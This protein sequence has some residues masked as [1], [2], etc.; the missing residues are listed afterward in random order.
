MRRRV[1]L[2]WTDVS[3]EHIASIFRVEKSASDEPAWEGGCDTSLELWKRKAEIILIHEMI[4][5]VTLDKVKPDIRYK[6][7]KHGGNPAYGL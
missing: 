3:E 7:L 4:I 2:V 5:F 1:D 6:R